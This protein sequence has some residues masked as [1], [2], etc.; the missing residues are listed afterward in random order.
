MNLQ[1]G[2]LVRVLAGKYKGLVMAVV[3]LDETS[4]F[5][6]DGRHRKLEKSKKLN[7]KHVARI[8]YGL[9]KEAPRE[10]TNNSLWREIR[11]KVR[12]DERKD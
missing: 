5:V 4:V 12:L 2:E 3:S 9:E 8:S 6:S 7:P 10:Y 11:Q 1:K